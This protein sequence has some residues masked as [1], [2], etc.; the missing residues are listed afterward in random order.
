MQEGKKSKDVGKVTI[1][2]ADY[3]SAGQHGPF[4]VSFGEDKK[5]SSASSKKGSS[6]RGPSI[7]VRTCLNPFGSPQCSSRC[8][9]MV[10]ITQQLQVEIESQWTHFNKKKITDK[11]KEGKEGVEIGGVEYGLETDTSEVSEEDATTLDDMSESESELE[12]VA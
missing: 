5:S 7:K 3:A 11:K 1:E 9:P 10:I 4:T 8:K 2:L 6:P 12:V